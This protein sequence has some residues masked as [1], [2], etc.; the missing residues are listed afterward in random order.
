MESVKRQYNGPYTGD[1]LSRIA[2]PLGGIGAGMICLE[3]T[4]TI[5]HFSIR[6]RPEL[7]HEPNMFSALCVKGN[8]NI[9]RVLEG[10]IPKRKIFPSANAGRDG[11]RYTSYGLP[12]FKNVSFDAKFP[13]GTVIL[14]DPKIPLKVQLTG[15]S[16]FV[17]GDADNSSLPVAALEFRFFNPTR[18]T[19]EATYCFTSRNMMSSRPDGGEILVT[20]NG[21]T[22]HQ[23]PA[24]EAPWEEG[25]FRVR[26][27]EPGV[28]VNGNLHG[29]KFDPATLLWKNIQEGN[30]VSAPAP[31]E[32]SDSLGGALFV[33]FR[34]PA[35][36]EKKLRLLMSWYVPK[37]NLNYGPTQECACKDGCGDPNY[38]PW[39][40]GRFNGIDAVDAYWQTHYN[41]L[42]NRSK[43]FSDTFY[44]TTLPPEVVEAVAANL[45]ILKSPTVLRQKDGRLWG[46]EGCGCNDGCCAGAC[47]HVWNYAQAIPHLFPDLERTLREAEFFFAQHDDGN[48]TFRMSLPTRPSDRWP[49]AAADG[50][51]GGIIKIY[52]E[53]RIAGDTDWLKKLW[54]KVRQ[55]LD[56]CINTWDPDRKGLVQEPHHNTYDVEFWGPDGMCGSIYAAAL[57]A[58]VQM[59]RALGDEVSDYRDLYPKA[60]KALETDLFNGEY[61]IQK[62]QGEGLRAGDPLKTP[63]WICI[64]PEDQIDL[65]KKEGPKYQYGKGCLSD[66][67][68]GA[69]LAEVCGLGTVLDPKKITSH[70]KA[71]YKYNLK[72]DLSE[73]TNPQHPGYALGNEGGV[74]LCTWPKGGRLT[75]PFPYSEEVWTGI[76]YQVASHLMIMGQVAKGLQIVRTCRN[77]YDGRIRNPFDEYECGNWYARAMSSY[78]LL[79]GLS[80]ARYDAVEKVLYLKPRIKGDFKSFL[81]TATGFGTVGVKNGKPFLEVKSGKIDLL[82]IKYIK[83]RKIDDP[84]KKNL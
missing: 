46:W 19:I 11:L 31:K 32:K 43:L 69:W 45:T 74:L 37:T 34:V 2:F 39:Y 65:L 68:L 33:P 54:P 53:W 47:T 70:L 76:E 28:T 12:R 48:Q 52:R 8:P 25:W 61:F 51:L 79:Q 16:P 4:G 24:P 9:A 14:N 77:R 21:F 22:F 30:C 63:T 36:K 44:D 23:L 10:P 64:Y 59:G 50:Q 49:H 41:D 1:Y 26:I 40:A 13:F 75:L 57:Y 3:G 83:E 81:S 78:G 42:H 55:S 58:A 71:V 82:N 15:W 7:D 66:G 27:D 20:K 38:V 18:H 35:G 6:N 73:H 29:G 67:V 17:P 62:I 72:N 84:A 60:R 56:Y 5:S 80:G